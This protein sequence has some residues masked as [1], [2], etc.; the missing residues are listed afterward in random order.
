MMSPTTNN[1]VRFVLAAATAGLMLA[2][3]SGPSFAGGYHGPPKPTCGN[4]CQ[5]DK[6]VPPTKLQPAK[7]TGPTDTN[8]RSARPQ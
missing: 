2:A 5:S 3:A 1:V 4:A 8:G 7:R 6:A